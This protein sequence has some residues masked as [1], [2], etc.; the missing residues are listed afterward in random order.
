MLEGS[1]DEWIERLKEIVID[2]G[3]FVPLWIAKYTR[4]EEKIFITQSQMDRTCSSPYLT[5]QI[6]SHMQLSKKWSIKILS[7]SA[8]LFASPSCTISGWKTFRS[9]GKILN[10]N[11]VGEKRRRCIIFTF[12]FAN[13]LPVKFVFVK[14]AQNAHCPLSGKTSFGK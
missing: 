1:L 6:A 12:C 2:E 11:T 10:F 3:T 9:C 7:A 4:L 14:T 5:M 13:F 8:P